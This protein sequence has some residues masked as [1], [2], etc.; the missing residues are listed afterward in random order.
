MYGDQYSRV[1]VNRSEDC[2]YL[3]IFTPGKSQNSVDSMDFFILESNI[4]IFLSSRLVVHNDEKLNVFFYVYGGANIMGSM[5]DLYGGPDFLLDQNIIL[6]TINYRVGVFGFLNLDIPEYS[7]NMAVKDVQMALKWTYE[8]IE[9][10]GGDKNQITLGG[11]SA[12]SFLAHLQLFNAESRKY[13]NQLICASGVANTWPMFTPQKHLCFIHDVAVKMNYSIENSDDLVTFL[14]QAP[15]DDLVKFTEQPV[16][17]KIRTDQW[18]PVTEVNNA[19]RPFILNEIRPDLY[20]EFDNLN[21][22]TLFTFVSD[23]SGAN[24]FYSK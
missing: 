11:H 13:F 20:D 9:F 1:I 21:I 2:L 6:V 24:V 5:N 4:M 8:N 19:I 7:G 14:K 17:L 23:V 15:S 10:F 3:N 18:L 12:G 16:G 22:T